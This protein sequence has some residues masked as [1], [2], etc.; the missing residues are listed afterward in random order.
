MSP[1]ER[2]TDQ[3]LVFGPFISNI[4]AKRQGLR[5]YYTG[6]P[7]K[8]G[9]VEVKRTGQKMCPTCKRMWAH[10]TNAAKSPLEHKYRPGFELVCACCSK[11][12]VDDGTSFGFEGARACLIVHSYSARYCSKSCMD[13]MDHKRNGFQRKAKRRKRYAEDSQFRETLLEQQRQQRQ[14][15][16]YKEKQSAYHKAWRQENVESIRTRRYLWQQEKLNSDPSFKLLCAMRHR[17]YMVLTERQTTK[18]QSVSDLLGCSIQEA[19]DHIAS[20]FVPGMTW[21]NHGK[22]HIDHIRP[23]ASFDLT[24][25][26]QQKE[27]FHYTN[28][29][30]LWAEDNVRKR[31]SL[32]W[33]KAERTDDDEA[34]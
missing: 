31:D 16:G 30:P 32:N 22:W 14:S 5:W 25:E 12:I 21:D 33:Q 26:A 23:C 9:H 15:P 24:D 1:T 11:E 19:K 20:Q 28:L 18:T 6:K 10:E 3:P 2:K 7:C 4:Q 29:Q 34:A 8:L 17:L 13:K 27:C